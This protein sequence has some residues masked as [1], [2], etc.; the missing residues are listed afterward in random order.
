MKHHKALALVVVTLIALSLLPAQ[1]VSAKATVIPCEGDFIPTGILD[2]GTWTYPGGNT[3]VRGMVGQYDQFMGDPR[4]SG[5][6]TV[7]TNAN[8]DVYMV[9]P[10]WGTF[11]MALA[12]GSPSGWDGT[13][14]GM[15]YPDGT[16]LI[17]V[18]GHGYGDLEGM[19]VFVNISFPG[20]FAPGVASGY[21]LDPH[22]G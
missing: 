1:A 19:K 11:H 8:W 16:H 20:L 21:I 22:G 12:D 2:P 15:S 6:N 17:R 14:T 3:H 9:G 10:M 18:E 5:S 13:W 4:C 7:V